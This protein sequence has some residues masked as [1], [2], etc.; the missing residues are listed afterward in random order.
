MLTLYIT[1]HGE[2]EWD[3]QRKMQGW[4]DS[5]LT[6]NGKRNA[7]L[8]GNRVKEINFDAIYSSPSKRTKTTAELNKGDRDIPVIIDDNLMEINMGK[9]E[10]Q[11]VSFIREKYPDEFHSFWNVL[12]LY[13][14]LNGE[15]FDEL[16]SRV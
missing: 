8:L 9:W 4:S 12:H 3:T 1:R 15:S 13:N 10:G 11:T 2:T 14:S 7:V 6:K 16:K 5:E